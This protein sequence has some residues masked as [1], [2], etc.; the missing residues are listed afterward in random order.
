[1]KELLS[2]DKIQNDYLYKI[3]QDFDSFVNFQIAQ[4]KEE[5]VTIGDVS[6]TQ[7]W[8]VK[9]NEVIGQGVLHHKLNRDLENHGGHI[10]YSIRP[11]FRRQGYGTILLQMMLDKAKEFGLKQVL[12]AV[13]EEN[14]PSIK[15][16]ENIGGVFKERTKNEDKIGYLL[17]WINL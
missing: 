13:K 11:S 9:D 5:S 6:K 10:G 7:Y 1:M 2:N 4:A 16:I 15:M 3:T 17:Y 14:V 8:L 12:L